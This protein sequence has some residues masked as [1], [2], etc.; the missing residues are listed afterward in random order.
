MSANGRAERL[1][2]RMPAIDPDAPQAPAPR[3]ASALA[4]EPTTSGQAG[5][6]A[7]GSSRNAI[8]SSVSIETGKTGDTVQPIQRH[9][10]QSAPSASV[11]SDPST[12]NTALDDP[13]A[14]E[15]KMDYVSFYIPRRLKLRFGAAIYWTARDR[16]VKE[17]IPSNMSQAVAA[18]MT[19]L[20]A[21]LEQAY[22]GGEVFP[23]S[24]DQVKAAKKRK[25]PSS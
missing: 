9:S 13:N 14:F 19:E 5:T 2:Q 12:W 8:G 24:E 11:S 23:P 22:N 1:R 18:Y 3:V 10:P 17:A 21:R 20:A 4:Q 7:E 15:D 25:K 6:P 16:N